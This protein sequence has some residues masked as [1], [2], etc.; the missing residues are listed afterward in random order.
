MPPGYQTLVVEGDALETVY[1][2]DAPGFFVPG[3][4]G[5]TVFTGQSGRLDPGG[6]PVGPVG[7][8]RPAFP[9]ATLP[10]TDPTFFLSIAGV[11]EP[12]KPLSVSIHTAGDGA[13]LADGLGLDEMTGAGAAK[14]QGADD[15]L[16]LDKRIHLIPA[17]RLLVTIP[18]TNDRLVLRRLDLDAILSKLPGD[19][20]LIVSPPNLNVRTGQSL[21]HQIDARS[22]KGGVKFSLVDGPEGL[23]VSPEDRVSWPSP[24]RENGGT[25]KA[26]VMVG[27]ASGRELFHTL[28][29]RV[30]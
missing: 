30:R 28:T 20:L 29:I 6:Q 1:N 5:R 4:D 23:T 26:V 16:T 8:K 9:V 15:D 7:E 21:V 22:G 13:R 24:R 25:S 14:P 17:A 12:S 27:D 11:A 2:R 19:H 3:T 10:S 18:P